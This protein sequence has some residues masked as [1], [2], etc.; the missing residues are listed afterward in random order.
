[1]TRFETILVP[2]DFSDHSREAL[3]TA[4]SSGRLSVRAWIVLE[5][6]QG[7]A[8]AAPAWQSVEAASTRTRTTPTQTAAVKRRFSTR[9]MRA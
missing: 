9:K 8:I 4:V 3:D 5:R 6:Q 1:M 2:V 7:N